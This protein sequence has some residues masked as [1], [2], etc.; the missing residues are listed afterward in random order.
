[1]LHGL[2]FWLVTFLEVS[3][4]FLQQHRLWYTF[5]LFFHFVNKDL[6]IPCLSATSH[7]ASCPLFKSFKTFSLNS[8]VYELLSFFNLSTVSFLFC[9]AAVIR[10]SIT[11]FSSPELLLNVIY[12]VIFLK[13]LDYTNFYASKELL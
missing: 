9:S 3:F 6:W 7:A 10:S 11:A 2:S 5:L 4:L 1:M 12:F 13:E 8:N